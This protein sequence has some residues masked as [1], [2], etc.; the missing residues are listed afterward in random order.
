VV[1]RQTD[2]SADGADRATS[3]TEAMTMTGT[4]DVWIIG[5]GEIYRAAI[6]FAT[7]L[8][9]TEVD[10][11]AAG[12]AYAPPIGPEWHAPD[13]AWRESATGPR[14]RIRRYTRGNPA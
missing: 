12:D 5:G 6:D 14:F 9:V 4:D 7:D 10:S 2:W 8:L 11:T 1:T 3:L 13:S